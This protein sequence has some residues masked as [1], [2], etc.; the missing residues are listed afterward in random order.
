MGQLCDLWGGHKFLAG[1]T[2]AYLGFEMQKLMLPKKT[3]KKNSR[4]TH[5]SHMEA[6]ICQPSAHKGP[7]VWYLTI[8]ESKT[9]Q[10]KI[11]QRFE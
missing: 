1:I 8:Q 5:G 3:L 9:V 4:Q 10:L 7:W 11:V 6:S 2:K